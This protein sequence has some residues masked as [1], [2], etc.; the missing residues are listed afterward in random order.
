MSKAAAPTRH[1]KKAESS[2]PV[3]L[4]IIALAALATVLCY[5]A[6]MGKYDNGL[7]RS[8]AQ[9]LKELFPG[10]SVY[11]GRVSADGP[12]TIVV[13]NVRMASKARGPRRPVLTAQRVVLHGD[14]DIAHWIQ[15][16]TKVKQAHLYGL[17]LNGWPNA[18]GSWSTACLIPRPKP[19]ADPPSI[20][21]YN[22]IVRLR[23]GPEDDANTIALHDISGHIEPQTDRPFTSPDNPLSHH[24]QPHLR[25]RLTGR[26]SG[27]L[28]KLQFDGRLDPK[29][30][31]WIAS[32]SIEQFNF[33]PKLLEQLPPQL[34]Q[35]LTQL[36]GLECLATSTFEI[37]ACPDEPT[38]FKIQGSLTAGRLRDPRLPY[39]LENLSSDFFCKNSLLQLRRMH[40]QSGG[41]DLEL[42]TDI[43][44]FRLDSPIV[45]HAKA[46]GLDLDNRLYQSL[47]ASWQ[48]Q[49]D[50]LSLSGTVGGSIDLK[51]DGRRWTPTASI[52]CENVAMRPWLF[53]YPLTNV[54]GLV[55]YQ[56]NTVSSK[57]LSGLAGGQTIHGNFSLSQSDDQ[58]LG[59][60]Q[61]QA[62]GPISIDE[63]LLAALTPRDK[64][65][66]GAEKFVRSLHPSGS[67]KL[68]NAT[69]ERTSPDDPTW[70]RLIDASIYGGS[71]RYDGFRYPIYDIRGR[72]VGQDDR[73]W[74]DKFEGRNDSGRILCSGE[75]QSVRL[76][77]VPLKLEFKA[78]AVPIAE[79]LKHA[80]PADAQ[81]VWE[82]LRPSGA[83]DKVTV[84]LQRLDSHSPVETQVQLTE[85]SAS[86]QATGRSLR[87]HPRT[88]PYLLSD[89]ACDISY[90]PGYVAIHKASAVNGA[91][92]L[93][94]TGECRP[95]EDGRWK[96]NV[97]WLPSTRLIVDR[98][99]LKALPKS[100]RES[101]LK[102]D[103]RGPVS[104]LGKSEILFANQLDV[105]PMT[106]W[107]CQL[108][109]EDGQLADGEHI[110]AL[111]G[112]VWSQGHSDGSQLT[113]SGNVAMDAL[114]VRG[115]PVT[116]LKGPFAL[117]G[118]NLY[119]GS[120][121]S[122]VLP[123]ANA[124]QAD[125]MTADAL[126]GKLTLAG[127]GRL[128]SGKFYLKADLKDAELSALLQDVGVYRATTKASCDAT[129]DFNGIPWNPQTYAGSG[130]IHL[131][132]AQLYELPFMI[133]L[134]RVA[135]VSASD[136]SAFQTAD[137]DFAI[138]GDQIPL[139]RI[140]CDGD[141]LRLRGEGWM[142]LR[143]EIDL[144]LYS[145]VGRSNLIPKL[146]SPWLAE[147]RYA[148]FMMIEVD[149]TLDNPVMQ[150]RPFP[151]L[152]RTLQQIF[153]EVAQRRQI[154]DLTPWQ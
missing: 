6:L 138:D 144:E 86:N 75:W 150:R 132:D 21:L 103:F 20:S 90:S 10:A 59:K 46:T 140:A 98:Q 82:E 85:D 55:G 91:S 25:A 131:S 36:S 114:T 52:Q 13:N 70:H 58:W 57:R 118:S 61:C 71:I 17:E 121:T 64:A 116:R 44:G 30:L 37:L 122:D 106:S 29:T 48:R 104:V 32:G 88:F 43:M 1:K 51:F 105:S 142:N 115:I 125:N 41:A 45:I 111:R 127:L 56:N 124:S 26:S 128:D 92:R 22:A 72:V 120:R 53:P 113:A 87:L 35:Y 8:V 18:D 110:G 108:D 84:L 9:H 137:I 93:S 135:S 145:Y 24:P 39:P 151:Q 68:T 119:F 83:I 99:L 73:W 81:F 139:P 136:E 117:R 34:A 94:L 14:L 101:L 54:T 154:S 96:A 77:S 130:S 76:G 89:A 50:R 7:R 134:L 12:G 148:T 78:F 67:V 3:Q 38:T 47:P 2:T 146:A 19:N 97:R 31:S 95:N 65:Q 66:T 5:R 23:K 69:F 33:S 149:G 74:L 80:L 143:R 102:I 16:T 60:L 129:L 40:A 42:S 153:P 147:S 79:E 63:Q 152:E 123:G 109:I 11:V 100:V 107:D 112:T 141:V 133:R 15:K 27:L 126:S 28:R 62:D 4:L 49:W